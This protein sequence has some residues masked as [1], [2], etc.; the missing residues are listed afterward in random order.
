MNIFELL[1]L[2]PSATSDEIRARAQ[3]KRRYFSNLLQSAPTQVLRDIY[4]RRL[5]DIDRF[6][7]ERGYSRQGETPSAAPPAARPA[8]SVSTGSA[9]YFL[10][11]DGGR[12]PIALLPGLNIVGR[13]P[14]NMGNPIVLDDTYVSANHAVLEVIPGPPATVQLYDI[15][16]VSSKPSTN[17]VFVNHSPHRIDTRVSLFDGMH[18]RF[19]QHGFI[20]HC[21]LQEQPVA[22]SAQSSDDES[23]KTVIIKAPFR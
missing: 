8:N 2:E 16:E 6:L 21:V 20:L 15:G 23:L 1:E 3:E 13:Q 14:R 11:P 18:V 10:H 9:G 22:A 7:E 12:S 17:G 19:G 4:T 5:S